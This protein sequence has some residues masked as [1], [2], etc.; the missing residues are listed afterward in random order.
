MN[1]DLKLLEAKGHDFLDAAHGQRD[2]FKQQ[3]TAFSAWALAQG[4]TQ[5]EV[6]AVIHLHALQPLNPTIARTYV[7][8]TRQ[9]PPSGVR[10]PVASKD[11][12]ELR[13]AHA[14]RSGPAAFKSA[15]ERAA[16]KKS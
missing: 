4:Y 10:E 5:A 7:P 16:S 13:E 9:A 3:E 2:F 12:R 15:K 11:I 14:G 1:A 8:P 6:V